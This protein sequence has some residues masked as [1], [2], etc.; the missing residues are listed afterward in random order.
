[1]YFTEPHEVGWAG[2]KRHYLVNSGEVI[3]DY[4]ELLPNPAIPYR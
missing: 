2:H 1:M 3:P 4:K